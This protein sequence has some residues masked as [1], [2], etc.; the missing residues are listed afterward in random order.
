MASRRLL[1]A[2]ATADALSDEDIRNVEGPSIVN[3]WASCV[4]L[5]DEIGMR[6]DKTVIMDAGI[7]NIH[8]AAL[9]LVNISDD[10]LVFSSVVG[11]GRLRINVPTLTTSL[12]FHL[13]VEPAI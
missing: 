4:T 2:T 12:I 13:S 7:M 1:V 6:L 3:L 9:S 10:Q 11:K 8:A 5:T